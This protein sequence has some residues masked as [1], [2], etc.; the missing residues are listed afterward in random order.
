MSSEKSTSGG[1]TEREKP[2]ESTAVEQWKFYADT[3][4]RVSDRRLKN[5]RFYL[6]LLLGLLGFAG[7]GSKLGLVG[8][9]ELGVIG[10]IGALLCVLW[11]F[12]ILSYKQ[13]NDSKYSTLNE[14]IKTLLFSPFESEW[15]KL[16]QGDERSVYIEHTS[17]EV[18][19]PRVFRGFH[20]N[21][22]FSIS[23]L[24][25]KQ[26]LTWP[27]IGFLILVWVGYAVLVISGRLPTQMY[28]DYTGK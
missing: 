11:V 21:N 16:K 12:H 25:D 10:I 14:I 19:W 5:N 8:R 27:A 28:W 9:V 1:K 3:T 17:V 7:A 18:W 2:D 26:N 24:L 22:Y 23:N 13:L 20:F 15:Q 6:C 4:Q